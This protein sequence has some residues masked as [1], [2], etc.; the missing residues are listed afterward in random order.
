MSDTPKGIRPTVPVPSMRR[1][2][3]GFYKDVVRE[4]KHVTWPTPRESSRLTGI[5]LAV[6][7][8]IVV[9]LMFATYFFGAIVHMIVKGA[10]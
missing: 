10:V 2:I 6:C 9:L 8:M 4:M 1:G 3:K 5:V 7:A